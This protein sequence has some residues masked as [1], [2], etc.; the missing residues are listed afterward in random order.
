MNLLQDISIRVTGK[1][2]S[3]SD[4]LA[5]IVLIS[6]AALRRKYQ[7][8]GSR[9]HD[10]LLLK[11]FHPYDKKEEPV[12]MND[13]FVYEEG[14][15]NGEPAELYEIITKIGTVTQVDGNL[16]ALEINGEMSAVISEK[17]YAGVSKEDQKK[18][19]KQL[20]KGEIRGDPKEGDEV[21]F[22]SYKITVDP[23][24][25]H[26]NKT[27]TRYVILTNRERHFKKEN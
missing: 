27:G 14:T 25:D 3:V 19:I 20:H 22:T 8:P 4:N 26:N 2:E 11:V 18:K 15:Y 24:N 12:K 21:L 6:D 23:E 10:T 17:I 16:V 1:V 9:I 13:S 5:H 7:D